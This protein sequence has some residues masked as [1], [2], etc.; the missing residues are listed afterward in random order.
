MKIT[1][2][3]GADVLM[4]L[5]VVGVGTARYPDKTHPD[6]DHKDNSGKAPEDGIAAGDSGYL[7][8][9]SKTGHIA[10]QEL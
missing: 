2:L 5:V 4:E 7:T 3:F 6:K 10:K 9:P 1:S 8:C